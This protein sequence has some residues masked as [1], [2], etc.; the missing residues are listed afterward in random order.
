MEQ[1]NSG[2]FIPALSRSGRMIITAASPYQSSWAADTEGNYDEFVYHFMSAVAKTNINGSGTVNADTDTNG[3]ISM[4]EAF[5]YASAQDSAL[6]NPYYD[7]DG[8]GSGVPALLLSALQ[9][10]GEGAFGQSTYL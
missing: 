4:Y 8:D 7:D 1:C 3:K 6:E 9:P 5:M 2:V 10:S